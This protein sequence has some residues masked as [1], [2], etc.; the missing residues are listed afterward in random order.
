MA[1]ESIKDL[2]VLPLHVK[3]LRFFMLFSI[4]FAPLSHLGIPEFALLQFCIPSFNQKLCQ[5]L[6]LL[7]PINSKYYLRNKYLTTILCWQGNFWTFKTKVGLAYKKQGLTSYSLTGNFNLFRIFRGCSLDSEELGS[8]T[9]VG[10]KLG[11][12]ECS[13]TSLSLTQIPVFQV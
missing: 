6:A 10:R 7:L 11:H 1:G 5:R 13:I 9:S 3:F 8:A 4:L 12:P 2:V